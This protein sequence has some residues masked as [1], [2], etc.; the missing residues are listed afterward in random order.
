MS[1]ST[2]AIDD[3][4]DSTRITR[5][6][7]GWL[8]TRLTG[9]SP[10]RPTAGGGLALVAVSA[11]VSLAAAGLLGETLRIRWSVGTYYGPEYAPTTIAL[12]AFPILVAVAV[13][14]FRGLANVLVRTEAGDRERGHYELAVLTVLLSLLVIQVTLVL[15]NLW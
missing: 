9:S 13:G 8:W 6:A 3:R 14:A 1:P 4:T 5:R 11:A 2:R 12:A 7:A 15:A 10:L